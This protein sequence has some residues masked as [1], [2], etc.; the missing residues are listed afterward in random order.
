MLME[1]NDR[2]ESGLSQRYPPPLLPK[3]A[4]DNVRLQKLKMK[5][6]KKKVSLSQTP[7]PFRSC[8][9]PVNEAS[10]DL[11]HSDLSSPPKTPDSVCTVE[12]L[13]STF[14]LDSLDQSASA[15]PHLESSYYKQI[16]NVLPPTYKRQ[17]R[18]SEEQVAP[19]Y[20][21]STFLFD[22]LTPG[23]MPPINSTPVPR[24]KQV[25]LYSL[26]AGFDSVLPNSLT[27]VITVHP[28]TVSEP[29]PKISTHNMTQ[30]S[31]ILNY[32]PDLT[33]SQV[34][35]LPPVPVLLS[36]ANTEKDHFRHNHIE[37][38]TISKKR[39]LLHTS[40]SWTPRPIS[41]GNFVRQLSQETRCD[42]PEN[43]MYTSKATINEITKPPS[44]QDLTTVNPTYKEESLVVTYM[45]GKAAE[46]T[47]DLKPAVPKLLC[48]KHKAASCT[49]SRVSTR[50]CKTY[51]T[52]PLLSVTSTALKSCQNGFAPSISTESLGR[53]VYAAKNEVQQ[54]LND[55]YNKRQNTSYRGIVV[56]N[57]CTNTLNLSFPTDA[58]ISQETLTSNVAM[59]DAA[60]IDSIPNLKTDQISE[61]EA[62]HL[63]KVPSFLCTAPKTPTGLIYPKGPTSLSYLL[64]TYHCPVVEARKSLS[65][66]LENQI[67]LATSKAKAQSTYHGLTPLQYAANGGIQTIKSYQSLVPRR[68]ELTSLTKV[69]LEDDVFF[70]KLDSTKQSNG[71]QKLP[72]LESDTPNTVKLV[73]TS[74][75]AKLQA[76]R[77]VKNKKDVF[78]KSHEVKT[79][80]LEIP[81]F[82]TSS[83]KKIRPELPFGVVQKHICQSTSD[84]ST[85]KASY[86]EV[87]IPIPKAGVSVSLNSIPIQRNVTPIS[88]NHWTQR[89][90]CFQDEGHTRNDAETSSPTLHEVSDINC[91]FNC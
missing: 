37:T 81:S 27:S 80:H 2:F 28:V 57:T 58:L 3:P 60:L 91:I 24:M 46:E 50:S 45:G 89:Q 4:K 67:S 44:N 64:P 87:P 88:A 13:C 71:H 31:A 83:L 47:K 22:E 69:Q 51:K 90:G 49:Q 36:I 7:I 43:L 20:E 73:S 76:E 53:K 66:L 8:L 23:M 40:I 25:P 6:V 72:A 15:F 54:N 59:P 78:E 1:V 84:V 62:A 85:R 30:S 9:S 10:T 70:S 33:P 52:D 82:E 5:R 42:G 48:G 21:C 16:D 55:I 56:Q 35:D 18:T 12:S 86:S 68:I 41:S 26:Q 29:N 61:R 74:K 39:T 11:E 19:L 77:T 34:A 75:D 14:P 17:I 79:Q 32:G 38:N 65:S 63:P